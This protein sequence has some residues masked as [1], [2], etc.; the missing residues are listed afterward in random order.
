MLARTHGIRKFDIGVDLIVMATSNVVGEG[1][2]IVGWGLLQNI[3]LFTSLE[4]LT[5]VWMLWRIW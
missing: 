1:G 3:R 2:T 4:K 5:N